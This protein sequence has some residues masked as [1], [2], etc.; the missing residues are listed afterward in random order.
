M[1]TPDPMTLLLALVAVTF[2]TGVLLLLSSRQNRAET[3]L[4]FWGAAKLVGALGLVLMGARGA[5]D[6][7]LVLDVAN[8]LILISHMLN[9]AGTSRFCHRPVAWRAMVAVFLA[10]LL[11]CQWPAFYGSVEWRIAVNTAIMG[12]VTLAAA[13][14]LWTLKGERLVSRGP[15]IAWL[16][17]HALAFFL[18]VPAVLIGPMP[19]VSNFTV[20]PAVT[21]MLFEALFHVTIMSFLQLSL[22]KDRAENRYRAAAETD[23][24]TGLP[25]R[26]AFFEQAERGVAEA[27]AKGRQTSVLV[28]DVDR[29][30]T[31]NDT[32][33]HAGGD[34]VLVA[35][36]EV[37]RAH[38]RPDD[39]FGR[40][41][42]EEFG[43]LLMDGSRTSALVVAEGLRARIASLDIRNAGVAIR[44]SASIGVS[45]MGGRAVSL[46][47]LL[48]EA[49]AGLYQ[50][51]RSGRDRV[52][53]IESERFERPAA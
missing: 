24:L 44:V 11:L 22:A 27:A 36:A 38:L 46:S 33:G 17:I 21:L 10:W 2:S 53:A 8:A 50:A 37:I 25:N 4:V 52:I 43:C 47:Q 26:R 45:T 13:A 7:H 40:I 18:R 15:A 51:K 19:D 32:H 23:V 3:S 39:R 30:K 9:W 35:V 5:P 28:I 42:G 16:V 29:F 48:D 6:A 14:T 41:G 20:S 12:V 31:I 49:D 1:P 34:R